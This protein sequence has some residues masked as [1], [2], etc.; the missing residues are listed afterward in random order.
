MLQ[1]NV[2]NG[3]RRVQSVPVGESKTE[4]HHASTVNINKI[5]ERAKRGIPP[6]I[7][8]RQGLYGDFTSGLDYHTM[9]NRILDAQLDFMS[10]PAKTRERFANDAGKLIEFISDP[11][12]EA[13]ARELGLLPDKAV[14]EVPP[15]PA[16]SPGEGEETPADA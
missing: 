15:E 12:N 2:V 14:P 5:V 9:C 4:Q 8:S 10:L 6:R 7:Q 1:E 13:E 3:R 11:G 16:A